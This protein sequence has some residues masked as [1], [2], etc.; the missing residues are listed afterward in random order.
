MT[1]ALLCIQASLY[2]LNEFF[3]PTLIVAVVSISVAAFTLGINIAKHWGRGPKSKLRLEIADS[4]ARG[5]NQYDG[6][7]S[8]GW[9]ENPLISV[10]TEN[11]DSLPMES[12]S[13][14]PAHFA[15]AKITNLGN[16]TANS[17]TF[18]LTSIKRLTDGE[19]IVTTVQPLRWSDTWYF[20][21]D[22][23]RKTVNSSPGILTFS[24]M[25]VEDHRYCDICFHYLE[26]PERLGRFRKGYV[27]FAV[28]NLPS[29]TYALE[30][31]EYEVTFNLVAENSIPLQR[32]CK[33]L[34]NLGIVAPRQ[35]VRFEFIS[36]TLGKIHSEPPSARSATAGQ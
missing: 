7:Y 12:R 11:E 30:N 24:T 16:F 32:K 10:S 28:A 20:Q 35:R 21:A 27:Y 4:G 5:Q 13:R 8:R 29:Q 18:S 26:G 31:G 23:S 14:V 25:P 2:L 3:T 34:I 9:I 15:R 17:I 36:E 1:G 6:L 33:L 19:A 22:Q